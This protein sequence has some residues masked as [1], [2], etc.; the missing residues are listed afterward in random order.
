MNITSQ[1][2]EFRLQ[3][4]DN[5]K[6]IHEPKKWNPAS[7]QERAWREGATTDLLTP[8]EKSGLLR[9]GPLASAAYSV[10]WTCR[11]LRVIRK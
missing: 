11:D 7:G 3:G 4:K 5:T 2:A 9:T 1:N 10:I 8:Q 6:N